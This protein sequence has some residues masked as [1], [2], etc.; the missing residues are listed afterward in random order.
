MP[1]YYFDIHDGV[2][3]TADDTGTE[4]RDDL[5]ARD[6]AIRAL[7]QLARDGLSDGRHVVF[8]IKVRD[9]TGANIFHASLEMRSG[10]LARES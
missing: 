2:E 4:C 8:W 9:Q 7:P 3:L 10:W 5:D 1:L 6:E